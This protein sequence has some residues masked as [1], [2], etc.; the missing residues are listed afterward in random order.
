MPTSSRRKRKT[1]LKSSASIAKK[2]DITPT[3]IFKTQKK[4]QKTSVNL[5]DLYTS[6]C[7]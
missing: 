5:D 1:S 7:N 3:N 6:D 4:S 2:R